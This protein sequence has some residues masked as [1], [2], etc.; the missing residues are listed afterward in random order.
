MSAPRKP[1]GSRTK[2]QAQVL[3]SISSKGVRKVSEVG[4]ELRKRSGILETTT[5]EIT[6]DLN[7][8]IKDP[9]T[10]YLDFPEA[11]G[12]EDT[13]TISPE[14]LENTPTTD[15]IDRNPQTINNI[16]LL[17]NIYKNY[18]EIPAFIENPYK[19]TRLNTTIQ[20]LSPDPVWTK[21][22]LTESYITGKVKYNLQR[23]SG[24]LVN[25]FDPEGPPDRIELRG[26]G[27]NENLFRNF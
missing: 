23:V 9:I 24:E 19:I 7:K 8:L 4:K 12:W 10:G 21:E 17:G 26:I 15:I 25:R 6:G 5:K 11:L 20:Q 13:T 18:D 16:N 1:V 22:E 3:E 14:E 2:N 27:Q